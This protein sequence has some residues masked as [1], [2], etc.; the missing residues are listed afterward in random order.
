M[1]CGVDDKFESWLGTYS[2]NDKNED[3]RDQLESRL[4]EQ[5]VIEEVV[6]DLRAAAYVDI[7]LPGGS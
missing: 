7:R 5:K 6:R 1:D 4:R 2:L 3:M